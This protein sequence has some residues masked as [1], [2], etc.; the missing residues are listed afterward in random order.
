MQDELLESNDFKFSPPNLT[1]IVIQSRLL[2]RLDRNSDRR[3]M[4]ILG[5]AA[6]GKTTLVASYVKKS[7][8][9]CAWINLDLEDSDP[10]NFHYSLVRSLQ[11]NVEGID[12]SE[13][14]DSP[15]INVGPREQVLLYRD[16]AQSLFKGIPFPIQMVLDGLDRLETGA[17]SFSFVKALI[18]NAPA[19]I[20]LI[21]LSREK[22]PLKIQQLEMN[23]E[24]LII[25]SEELAFNL[26]EIKLFFSRLNKLSLRDMVV[27]NIHN[28]TE[29]WVGGLRILSELLS[30]LPENNEGD[31]ELHILELL[32]GSF[33][34]KAFEYFEEA[35]FSPLS[36]QIKQFLMKSS[37]F[38][39]IELDFMKN[40][41]WELNA[42]EMLQD[43][44]KRNLFVVSIYDDH[45]GWL[46]RYHQLFREFLLAKLETEI[47]A[48]KK[49]ALCHKAGL[50]YEQRGQLEAATKYYLEAGAYS[51]A[52]GAIGR[53]GMDL[54]K[55]GRTQTLFQ[56]LV[57]LPEELVQEDPWLLCYLAMCDQFKATKKKIPRLQK[58]LELFQ[59]AKKMRGCLLS[60]GFL[61]EALVHQGYYSIPLPRLFEQ[62]E[63]FL[64]DP[65]SKPYPY[66]RG[67]LWFQIGFGQTVSGS[68]REA[69]RASENAY[70]IARSMGDLHLQVNVLIY[71][72]GALTF[73]GEFLLGDEVV[74]EL[75]KL[76]KKVRHPGMHALWRLHLGGFWA[77]RGDLE[78]ARAQV[79][80]ANDLVDGHGLTA[81]LPVTLFYTLLTHVY[82]GNHNGT[83]E[84][85]NLLL[86]ISSTLD[87]MFFKGCA[88]L[89]T[90]LNKYFE[91]E[92]YNGQGIGRAGLPDFVL[93][94]SQGRISCPSHENSTGSY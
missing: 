46:F 82:S 2:R 32:Q 74:G 16:W 78:K 75:D 61:I 11:Q 3:L 83:E 55:T 42:G 85:G 33:I 12:L 8:R 56:W 88:L 68:P 10:A 65:N 94:R 29:G 35:V 60:L 28:S 14:I 20:R 64:N 25:D 9:C 89:W 69:L 19:H 1:N 62:G 47:S 26:K 91:G 80:K 93:G 37:L 52:A 13:L 5:Q 70:A 23:Q 54:L 39:T 71:R 58:A 27:A 22:P 45:R 41:S 18:D 81:L 7:D 4:L 15:A 53:L 59:D 84:A 76:M 67:V 6:Q 90:G 38:D 57:A 72:M 63:E 36:S 66:E 92:L 49:R 34:L 43:L 40:F 17:Q 51:Q 44:T 87:N 50:L 77:V 21:L 48:E 24:G 30:R 79:K 31:K 86:N 73:M